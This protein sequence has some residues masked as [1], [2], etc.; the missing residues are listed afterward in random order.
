[1]KNLIRILDQKLPAFAAR[2]R[3][4]TGKEIPEPFQKNIQG[5]HNTIRHENARLVSV[6]FD[7]RGDNNTIEIGEGC[8]L[9]KVRFFIRG[10]NHR[11]RIENGV[12][13]HHGAEIWMEDRDGSLRI[14]KNSTFEA[15]HIAVT[16]PGSKV[17]IGNE[18]MF[19]YDIDVRTG[20]SH[21]ILDAET[22]E[23]INYAQDVCIGDRVWVGAHSLIL[24]GVRLSEDSVVAGGSVVTRPFD[25]EGII[26]GGN[27]AK[28]I[29]ENITWNRKRIYKDN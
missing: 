8:V 15:V 19:A 29:K 3:K 4:L 23:R 28:Q 24:K 11:I 5:N 20:D 25:Q 22:N 16:E 18:C 17:E 27:P 7:I 12:R 13:V 6:V 2:L 26:V 21:S 10:H 1:M 9:K 14:G